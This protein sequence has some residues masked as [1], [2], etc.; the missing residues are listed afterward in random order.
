M[1]SGQ[2][3]PSTRIAARR[4]FA[5]WSDPAARPLVRFEGVSKRFSG[6][7]A[8]DGVSLDIFEG[9]FFADWPGADYR[10]P[11]TRD[12][13]FQSNQ[14]WLREYHVDGFRY[15]YVPGM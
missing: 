10:Q 13:F 5:P 3:Q 11:F 14:Y 2:N 1:G 9:E 8:V 12:Y 4:T 15:D 6:A 7:A